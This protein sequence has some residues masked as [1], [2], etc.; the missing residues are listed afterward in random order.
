VPLTTGEVVAVRSG[1][2]S[3]PT[4]FGCHDKQI[5]IDPQELH[6]PVLASLLQSGACLRL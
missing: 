6:R 3:V 4:F 1:T 2:Q 5:Y